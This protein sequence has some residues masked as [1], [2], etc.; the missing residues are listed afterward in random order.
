M[1]KIINEDTLPWL[2]LILVILMI[3]VI[4][5]GCASYENEQTRDF[6]SKGYTQVVLPG[7]TVPIWIKGTNCPPSR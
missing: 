5:I 7:S 4:V 3:P 1:E 6:T 2:A